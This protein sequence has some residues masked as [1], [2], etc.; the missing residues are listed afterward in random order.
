MS[1]ALAQG[2]SFNNNVIGLPGLIISALGL[3]VAACLY[4]K[5]DSAPTTPKED[6]PNAKESTLF[7]VLLPSRLLCLERP[8]LVYLIPQRFLPSGAVGEHMKE[9]HESIAEGART[10]LKQEYKALAVAATILFILV[11][12]AVHWKTGLCY[13]CGAITSATCGYI[14]MMT[15]THA[16]VRTAAAAEIGLQ[17]ALSVSFNS[18]SIMGLTVVSMGLG[19]ISVLLMIFDYDAIDGVGALSGFGM[20]AGTVSIFA[21]VGGGIFTKAADVGADLVGK[22]EAGIPEDDV[23]NPATIAD[24]VGTF[25]ATFHPPIFRGWLV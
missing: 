11:S 21:R 5:N 23:R 14:G 3:V 22:V 12:A 9:I 19:M 20:G 13:L 4:L 1:Y 15:A 6:T 17:A 8:L 25:G 24:N 2:Y 7:L 10:F 18:G 16:N